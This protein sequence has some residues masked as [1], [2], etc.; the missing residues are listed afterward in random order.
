MIRRPPRSTLFP[1]PTLFRSLMAGAV[2]SKPGVLKGIDVDSELA[3]SGT[4]RH[5]KE[6]SLDLLRN[7]AAN[8]PGILLGKQ[9]VNDAGIRLNNRIMVLSPEG[10]EMNP[11]YGPTPTARPFKVA[12]V[13]ESGFYEFDDGQLQHRIE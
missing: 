5:L 2:N 8:P 7:P 3:I 10:G 6:G 1:Y 12:G 4:L 13:F 11:L 9:L